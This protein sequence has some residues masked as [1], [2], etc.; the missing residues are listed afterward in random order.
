MGVGQTAL[1]KDDSPLPENGVVAK[2]EGSMRY[3]EFRYLR[4]CGNGEVPVS[5][6]VSGLEEILRSCA[7]VS[8]SLSRRSDIVGNPR[9]WEDGLCLEEITPLSIG[10]S[11]WQ[12]LSSSARPEHLK[13]LALHVWGIVRG[14]SL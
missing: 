8:G 1:S 13:S 4:A 6:T 2:Q 10:S 7:P 14:G 9:A 11:R 3:G 12:A 5:K